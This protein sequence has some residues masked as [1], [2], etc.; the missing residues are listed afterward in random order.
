MNAGSLQRTLPGKK[1]MAKASLLGYRRKINAP[2]DGYLYLNIVPK[3]KWKVGGVIIK[4]SE[5]DLEFLKQREI[6]YNCLDVSDRMTQ[7]FDGRVFTF[8]APN[9]E[10]PKFKIPWSYINTCLSTVSYDKR[11]LWLDETIIV[12][13]IEYDIDQ[14]VYSLVAK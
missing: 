10:Y 4:I 12:N 14:P 13:D 11:D 2:V 5:Q 1:I 7:K 8:V 3:K 6:G 9:K